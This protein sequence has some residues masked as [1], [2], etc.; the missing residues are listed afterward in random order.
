MK[1][2]KLWRKKR[3]GKHYGAWWA[4]L[5][6]HDLNLG[7]KDAR[8]AERKLRELVAAQA[9]AATDP[10]IPDPPPAP[11]PPAVPDPAPAP[12][13]VP[14]PAPAPPAPDPASDQAE[15]EATN[16]AAA[17]A[18]AASSSAPA[19]APDLV[20]PPEALD[21][22]LMTGAS[23]LVE[24]QLELQ[25]WVIKKRTGKIAGKLPPESQ[26]RDLAAQAWVSQFKKWFP[27]LEFVPPWVLALALPM[28][29]M[30]L[31]IANAQEPTKTTGSATSEA[32]RAA[33]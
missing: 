8:I 23:A 33:A 12:A 9:A 31:Q 15:A 4:T 18:A 7:N 27:D 32:E 13:P 16:E 5:D 26:L 2:P 11:D 10:E 25:A 28:L 30:P 17:G 19:A 3:G 20:I 14:A 22:M 1:L 29:A 6:G 21:A 24:V